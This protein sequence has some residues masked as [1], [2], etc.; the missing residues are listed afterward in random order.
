M[1]LPSPPKVPLVKP[2]RPD[3]RKDKAPA[4]LSAV[5]AESQRLASL[6][7]LEEAERLLARHPREL[8]CVFRRGALLMTLERWAEAE[9]CFRTLLAAVP[10]HFDC[11]MGLAGA[12]VEQGRAAEALPLLDAAAATQPQSGRIRYF[13]SIALDEAGH[14]EDGARDL[15]AARTLL[16]GQAERRDF[17]PWEVYVQVS[18]RCNLR[19]AMCGHEVWQ[20]NSGFMEQPLFDRVL[21][22]CAAH[23]VR[24]INI[25]AGQGEP[26]LHPRIFEMLEQAVAGGFEV[27]IVTNGTPLTP[28]RCQ[29]L[30]KLG[31]ASIQFSFAGWDAESY[32]RTYVGA[33]FDRTLANLRHLQDAVR[34]TRTDFFVKAVV[35]GDDWFE[36][37]RRTRKF[38]GSHGVDKV[39]T[40]MANN[41]GGTVKCGTFNERHGVWSLKSLDHHRRMPCRVFLSAVGVFCDGTVT[42]CGC[43]DS[44]A[45]LR[46]GH[47]MEQTLAEIR[48][49]EPFRRILESFRTGDLSEVPMCG[50]C[51]DPFR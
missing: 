37:G 35:A 30:G 12:L 8:E 23:G 17:V 39:F 20:N 13:R 4:D 36:V 45:R 28:E 47:I 19:C 3:R 38:L 18:R 7:R 33:R 48:H 26:M 11:S 24:K 34:G 31:L 43:Y 49:G 44:N 16:V 29:R 51:D 1:P 21:E 40:V 22:Q 15:A 50:E 2:K 41:F 27:H 10:G 32:E 42:A 14:P 25:L 5:L 9:K 46:I 6:Q